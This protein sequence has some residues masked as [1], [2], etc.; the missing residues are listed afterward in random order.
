MENPIKSEKIRQTCGQIKIADFVKTYRKTAENKSKWLVF[1][2]FLVEVTGLEP[3]ISSS[4]TMRDTTFATPRNGKNIRFFCK[5][6]NMWSDRGIDDFSTFGRAEKV[7]VFKG[8]RLFSKILRRERWLSPETG[9]LPTALHLVNIILLNMCVRE[10]KSSAFA[11]KLCLEKTIIFG[12]KIGLDKASE[13]RWKNGLFRVKT[14]EFAP[15]FGGEKRT[16][17]LAFCP[18]I[19]AKLRGFVKGYFKKGETVGFRKL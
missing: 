5:W 15:L 3:A 6:S 4:R 16:V 7:S 11:L 19:I 10:V 9:A 1:G 17:F 12:H 8:F 2:C 18:N 14:V 13:N